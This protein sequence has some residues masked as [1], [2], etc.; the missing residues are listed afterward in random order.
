MIQMINKG[1]QKEA[2]G[3]NKVIAKMARLLK[4]VH[5]STI[6]PSVEVVNNRMDNF[7]KENVPELAHLKISVQ[8]TWSQLDGL[9]NSR[10]E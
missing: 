4:H 6:E 7:R 9:S 8:Y 1:A 3:I 5:H 10:T 2:A